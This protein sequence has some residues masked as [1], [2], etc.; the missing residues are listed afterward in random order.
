MGADIIAPLIKAAFDEKSCGGCLSE[1][2]KSPA[3]L[4]PSSLVSQGLHSKEERP[5]RLILTSCQGLWER[6]I[7]Y[8]LESLNHIVYASLLLFSAVG[9]D[10]FGYLSHLPAV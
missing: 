3:R 1:G 5:V 2:S 4:T 10:S 6:M 7:Q 9:S 8:Y